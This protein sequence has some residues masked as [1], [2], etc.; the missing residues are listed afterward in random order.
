MRFYPLLIVPAITGLSIFVSAQDGN[1]GAKET[2]SIRELRKKHHTEL[3]TRPAPPKPPAGVFELISFKS[4]VGS[5][6]A[7]LTPDPRDGKK[8]PV[9]IWLVGGFS[10]SIGEN[11]WG[12]ADPSND[13]SAAGYRKAGVPMMFPS[14][15]GGN[16]NPGERE[17][18]FGEVEDVIAAAS[19]VAKLPWVDS[20]RIYLGGHSTGGTLALL[21]AGN[22]D[23]FRAVISFGPVHTVSGYGQDV[24]PFDVENKM[25][26]FVRAPIL[27][28]PAIKSPTYVLEGENRGNIESVRLMK[29]KNKNTKVQFFEISGGDHFSILNPFNDLLAKKILADTGRECAITITKEDIKAAT[30]A[31]VTKGSEKSGKN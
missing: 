9:I 27:F 18:L 12:K 8:Y 24:L 6:A 22:S 30:A 23:L 25:E 10:N 16:N 13:Q 11:S 7:Y 31:I 1:P 26:T 5:L 14:L 20:S 21:V 29:E 3:L 19:H 28:L 2:G 17:G 15:R 4:P